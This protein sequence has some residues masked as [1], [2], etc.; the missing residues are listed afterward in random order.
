VR[1]CGSGLGRRTLDELDARAAAYT[2]C[3]LP[4]GGGSR[5]GDPREGVIVLPAAELLPR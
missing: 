2:A 1:Y 4:S 5:A 3:L